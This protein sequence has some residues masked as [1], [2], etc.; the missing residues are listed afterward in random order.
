MKKIFTLVAAIVCS[1]M[2]IMAQDTRQ[3]VNTVT[4]TTANGS[5]ESYFSIGTVWSVSY[6]NQVGLA[7][8]APSGAP[9]YC[10]FSMVR[11]YKIEGEEWNRLEKDASSVLEAGNYVVATQLRIDGT[12]GTLYR[13]P[14][15]WSDLTVTVDGVEW[16]HDDDPVDWGNV[17]Y[18]TIQH[19]FT[20]LPSALDV[21]EAG[22][23]K[24]VKRI[25]DGQIVIERN[26]KNF[27]LTGKEL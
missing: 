8:S 12:D 20:L 27:D 16:V 1:G 13:F 2:M 22:E 25:K 26:G 14:A 3:V 17:T 24:A 11:L 19:E 9:Y 18:T 21:P 6:A 7:F 10:P 5:I 15:S 23:L 4:L